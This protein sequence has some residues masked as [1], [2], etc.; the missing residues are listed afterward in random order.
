MYQVGGT[1]STRTDGNYFV[2]YIRKADEINSQIKVVGSPYIR[3]VPVQTI[4]YAMGCSG[5][6]WVV[7]KI[8][9][10]G[11]IPPTSRR[12]RIQVHR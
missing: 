5:I 1:M 4:P 10:M 11:W 3:K 12:P 6:V 2:S 8:C 7:Q 9:R